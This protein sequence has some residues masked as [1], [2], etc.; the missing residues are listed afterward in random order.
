MEGEKRVGD[1][2]RHRSDFSAK[3]TSDENPIFFFEL[4]PENQKT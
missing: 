1:A 3:T 2:L 4:E